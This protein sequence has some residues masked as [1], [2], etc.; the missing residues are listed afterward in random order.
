MNQPN[1]ADSGDSARRSLFRIGGAATL[2]IPVAYLLAA[3]VNGIGYNAA[4]FPSTAAEW[5]ATFQDNALIGLVYL[6]FADVAIVL[7]SIPMFLALYESLK[8][9]GKVWLQIAVGLGFVGIA[10]YLATNTA[11]TMH[12]LSKQYAA[13]STEA[14]Q[15]LLLAAG[16]ATLAAVE[17]TGA[18]YT[19]LPLTWIACMIL[20]ILMLRSPDFPRLT[21]YVGIVAF[22]LLCASVPIVGYTT[23]DPTTLVET[24][25]VAVSYAF[26]GTLSLIWYILVGRKLLKLAALSSNKQHITTSTPVKESAHG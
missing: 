2:I 9:D 23:T 6:G 19:G 20:S 18:K 22:P 10:V 12:Y 13:A 14:E 16:Q 24:I 26:G 4:P 17:G 3:I 1:E 8:M 5:F 11:L 21:A 7:V 25:I 15:T